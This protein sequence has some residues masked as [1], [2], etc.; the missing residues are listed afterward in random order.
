[1]SLVNLYNYI[2]QAH[3]MK[4]TLDHPNLN[5]QPELSNHLSRTNGNV[6][7][8]FPPEPNGHLHIGHAKAI[9]TNFEY[10]TSQNGIC[11]LRYDDTNP[12]LARANYQTF[13]SSIETDLRWLG[14]S[15]DKITRTSDYFD[16]MQCY[17]KRLI[18]NGCAYVC[19]LD[20]TT[21]R[22]NR[23]DEIH[24]PFRERPIEE[25]LLLFELMCGGTVEP[26]KMCLRLKC[27][28]I[29]RDPNM[30][31]PVIYRI[32]NTTNGNSMFP[33]YDYSHPIADSIEDITHS[34]CSI[35]F[36]N[37][38]P[39]YN[40]V[41]ETLELYTP[42]Q[43]EYAKLK[44][45]HFVLS[46]RKLTQIVESGVVSG[47]DDPRLPTICGMRRRG[48]PSNAI[49]KFCECIGTNIGSF[50]NGA[51]QFDSLLSKVRDELE[52]RSPRLFAVKDPL[53]LT[54]INKSIEPTVVDILNFPPNNNNNANNN[55]ANNNANNNNNVVENS[56][57]ITVGNVV[58]INRTDFRL[59]DSKDYYRLSLG[60]IVRLKYLGL[61]KAVEIQYVNGEISNIFCELIS[62]E[63]RLKEKLKI[64]GTITWVS[65]MDKVECQV[66]QYTHLFPSTLDK[67]K[68]ILEQVDHNSL[69]MVTY[70]VD[71]GIH[72]IDVGSVVQIERIGY[73]CVDNTSTANNIVLNS[74][75]YLK[76]YN[77]N[78]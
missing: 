44:I 49:R 28:N 60:K 21:L 20:E 14:Y 72:T 25:N 7:T 3:P 56:H 36:Y 70:W 41:L 65:E 74:T 13:I 4:L 6:R 48:Y 42:R 10:A 76:N 52:Q 26:Q 15:P 51:V 75:C 11:I 39:L 9:Y 71:S 37:H 5:K 59:I 38:R 33:T 50:S 1:M 30:Y 2:T 63:T 78:L 77:S 54:L 19:Q 45:E 18:S 32:I 24:S 16:I 8:R 62:E 46:K 17:A 35:E 12:S 47:W 22:N 40:K 57:P 23:R 31:D 73:F 34:L 53:R 69:D 43:I 68:D 64:K 29:L 61:I 58:Y 67:N 27:N 55:N 66:N